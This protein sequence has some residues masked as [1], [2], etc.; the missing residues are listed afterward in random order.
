MLLQKL[1]EYSERIDDIAPPGYSMKPVRY[2]IELDAAGNLRNPVPIDLADKEN[3]RGKRRPLP[4]V[5]RSSGI[6]PL[7][8]ADNAEYT[9]NLPREEAKA[10]RVAKSHAAY[11]D[12]LE[13][14]VQG[15]QE[16]SAAAVLH[17]LQSGPLDQL[18]LSDEFDRSEAIIFRVNDVFPTSQPAVQRFWAEQNAPKGDMMQCLIC[19]EFRPALKRLKGKIKGIPGG[20]TS[21]TSLISANADA[22]ESYGLKASQTAPVCADCADRFT[23]SLNRLLGDRSTRL[24]YNNLVFTFWTR[25]PIA[26]N[27]FEHMDAPEESEVRE[28]LNSVRSGKRQPNVDETAFY[29]VSLS[30]SGARAVVRDWVDTTVG[31]VKQSLARWF[32]RQQIVDAWGE[33]GKPLSLY[34]L[35]VSTVREA[36][37]IPIQT[38]KTLLHSALKGTP[39]P[40]SLLQQTLRRNAA[41]HDVTYSRAAL[42]KLVLASQSI[43]QEDQMTQLQTDR[44]EPAYHCGRLLSVL[45]G[46]QRAALGNVNSTIVDRFYGTASTAPASVFGTLLSGTQPHLSKL[47]RSGN[48][49]AAYR[50]QT[51]LEEVLGQLSGFP[52][53]LKLQDQALFALGYYHQ[54]AHDRAQAKAKAAQKKAS[55]ASSSSDS[56][57]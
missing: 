29:A 33:A 57:G 31:E 27:F 54:R 22:F 8:L 2:V 47:R 45:E 5:T 56:I 3:K 35:A 23:K 49:G 38:P 4:N 42:I 10:Q 11:M 25:K 9:F 48:E 6:K 24:M 15:T 32:S 20:Q 16:T 40:S 36:K 7:L 30:A 53:T 51:Q 41:E 37:D 39:L 19:G 55:K 18:T 1:V 34:R 43:I 21:G 28:L 12:L 52:R 17:F 50:L 44:T 14:C 46:I 26:F 13:A